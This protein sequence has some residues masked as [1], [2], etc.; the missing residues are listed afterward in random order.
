MFFILSKVL[1]VFISP[2]TWIITA[3]LTAILVRNPQRKRRWLAAGFVMLVFFTNPLLRQLA[4]K[5][6][7]LPVANHHQ[8]AKHDM[9]IVLGGAMR[10]YNSD[11]DRPVY[12]P[13]VERLMQAAFLYRRKKV[14]KI[15]LS[16]GSGLL[17]MK[18]FKESAILKK[19]LADLCVDEKDILMENQSRNTYENALYTARTLQKLNYKGS[20]LLITS[21]HHMRRSLACFQK[22]G[23]NVT[24]FAVDSY[25]GKI[26]WSPDRILIPDAENLWNWD[27]LIHEWIGCIAYKIKGYI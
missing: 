19:E 14:D 18:Q 4:F 12:G 5:M 1:S 20:L 13:A 23:L 21:A 22:S 3:F 26:I 11:I 17:L 6:W 27:L 2:L 10:Y 9:A 8:V 15:F 25:A 16:G 7:E 24:P